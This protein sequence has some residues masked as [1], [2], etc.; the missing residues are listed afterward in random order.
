MQ[1]AVTPS[2]LG[3]RA[4]AKHNSRSCTP[5]AVGL[6]LSVETGAAASPKGATLVKSC[7]CLQQPLEQG[8]HKPG[9]NEQLTCKEA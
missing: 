8:Q 1:D 3:L 2:A 6:G 7:L 4:E 9:R 5:C